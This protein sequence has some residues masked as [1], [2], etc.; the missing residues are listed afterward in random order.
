MR[1]KKVKFKWDQEFN[2]A[3]VRELKKALFGALNLKQM[4]LVEVEPGIFRIDSGAFEPWIIDADKIHTIPYTVIDF[5]EFEKPISDLQA[6]SETIINQKV[7]VAVPGLGL[8][9]IRRVKIAENYGTQDL[10]Q[11]LDEGWQIMAICPQPDQRRPDYVLGM[12]KSPDDD[13]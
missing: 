11:E 3:Q 4:D 8:L 9:A 5:I 2:Q 1:I 6:R 10:Q 13:N 7:N 12:P